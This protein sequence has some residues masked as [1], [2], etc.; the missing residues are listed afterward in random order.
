VNE[1]I[2][3]FEYWILT[4][5]A[6]TGM[7]FVVQA[8]DLLSVYLSIE[9]QSLVFYVLASFKRTSE[10]ST[11]SGLKY[12]ILGAFSSA[13][14]LF[15]S[16]ILYSLTGL[17]NFYDFSLFFTGSLLDK[18]GSEFGINI[19]IIFVSTAFLF[20]LSAAPFHV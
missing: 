17:T 9:F 10:F 4:L 13:L 2:N 1:K 8:I 12:F 19:G 16:S 15:G 20:K 6:V 5:L 7:L 14:L 11:E 18:A 3:S